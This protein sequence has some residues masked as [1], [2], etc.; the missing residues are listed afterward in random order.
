MVLGCVPVREETKL[1]ITSRLL[2]L[3]GAIFNDVLPGVVAAVIF[4][5]FFM[6]TS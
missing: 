6:A 4:T 5:I 3:T 2:Q 1:T